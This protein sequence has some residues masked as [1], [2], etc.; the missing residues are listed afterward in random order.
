MKIRE[1]NIKEKKEEQ[2]VKILKEK[3]WHISFA[4][5]CTGGMAAARLINVSSASNVIDG[6]MITY[7]NEVKKKELGVPEELME[8]YGVVSEEV[9]LAMAKGISE[10]MKSEVGVGISGIAGPLGGTEKKPVGMVCFGFLADNEMW[11]K[12]KYFGELGRNCVR[13]AAVEFVYDELL[14]WLKSE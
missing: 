11:T 8:K 4:E 13:E 2:L 14:A 12:T 6:S 10:K 9:A 1:E 5:S 7:S 3:G